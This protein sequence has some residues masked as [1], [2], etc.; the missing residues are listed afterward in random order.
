M[1]K[2]GSRLISVKQYRATD[3]V[4]FAVILAVAEVF[5]HFAGK[6]FPGGALYTFS[7]TVPIILTVMMRWGWQ[8]VLYAAASGLLVSL[9]SVKTATGTQYAT[10]IIGNAFIAVMLLPLYLIGKDKIR[11]KWW[12]SAL[13][14]VGGWL[15]VY[16]GRSVIW[17]IAFA[18][19]PQ[20]GFNAWSGFSAYALSDMFSL[21][22]AVVVI[23]VLRRLD[24]LFEDQISYLKRIDKERRD[25]MRYDDFGDVPVEIDEEAL[26]I[27]K[28]DNDLYD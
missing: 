1:R 5:T 22:M 27:L 21:V 20:E 18:I 8:S 4:I 10:Y 26:S 14:A 23:V 7:L 15:C 12:R 25:K 6:W 9:L 3:L 13:F 11:A 28:R 16:V 19:A 24:G 2:N 17:A